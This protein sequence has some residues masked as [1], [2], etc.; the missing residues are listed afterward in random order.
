MTAKIYL[1]RTF[2]FLLA[3]AL[4]VVVLNAVVDPYAVA[5]S[6]RI[7]GLNEYKVDIN[8]H[9][10]LMKKYNP[11]REQHNALIVGNSR[12]EM[13]IN[14]ANQ[15]FQNDG[16]KVYNLG[17]P[18]A[19]V[20]TQLTYALNLI[21][22]EDID[23]VFLSLDLTDFIW[24]ERHSRFDDSSLLEHSEGG[25]RLTASGQPNPAYTWTLLLDYYGSLFSLDALMASVKTLA[26]QDRAGPDRDNAGFNPARDFGEAVRIEGTRALFDQKMS[27]LKEHFSTTWY[28]RD[29][30]G[31]LDPSFDDLKIFLDIAVER[32]INVY[33]FVN[34]FHESYWDLFREEGHMPLH[35]EWLSALETLV[36]NYAVETVTF[37]DFSVES[38]FIH[39]IIPPQGEKLGPLQWFWEPSHYREQLGDI[40]IGTMLSESC[41]TEATFGRRLH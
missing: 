27:D 6:P 37:W 5:G 36:G 17:V 7:S 15:C 13:G 4:F 26:G 30:E 21:Y 22:Q 2:L 28:L 31:R 16:M 24:T 1:R 9:V 33:L 12:V 41:N 19:S 38:P 29:A 40:M 23:T 14:P 3:I 39:E 10:R 18:G 25:F 11:L 32:K 35:V 20:R 8:K 34:P